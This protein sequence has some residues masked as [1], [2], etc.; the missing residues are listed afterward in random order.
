MGSKFLI[1]IYVGKCF[2][3]PL[4]TQLPVLGDVYKCSALK[5]YTRPI[6]GLLNHHVY[7]LDPEV[8]ARASGS[9]QEM[10]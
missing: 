6:C 2:A 1:I 9:D 8:K 3:G 7:V 5:Q 10:G 4:C